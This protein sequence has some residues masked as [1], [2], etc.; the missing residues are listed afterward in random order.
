[1]ND[2]TLRAG[3]MPVFPS[4]ERVVVGDRE[5]VTVLASGL[6]LRDLIAIEAMKVEMQMAGNA[7]FRPEQDVSA[8]VADRAYLMAEAMLKRGQEG[9]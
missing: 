6:T 7:I 2:A 8:V 1:M 3:R 5:R 4:S 9:S